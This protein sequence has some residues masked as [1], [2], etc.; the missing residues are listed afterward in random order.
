MQLPEPENSKSIMDAL[1]DQALQLFTVIP[2]LLK[3]LVIFIIGI[4]LAKLVRRLIHRLLSAVGVDK[5][6]DRLMSIDM[7]EKSKINL[8][9]STIIATTT[10]YF[11]LIIFSMA[12]VEA[13]GL[14]IIS[15]LLKDLIEYIPNGVT[16]FLVLVIGIFIADAVKKLILT[17]CRSLGIRSGN[18]IANIVFYFIMLNIVLIALRQAKLQTEFM[19]DNM[20]IIL[21]GIAGAFAIGYGLASKDVITSILAGF[22][23]RDKFHVG[24]EITIDGRRGEVITINNNNIIIRSDESEHVIPYSKVTS[25][26]VEIH[27]RR[28]KGPALPPHEG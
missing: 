22:Y 25:E 28:D 12:A 2:A 14:R 6:A 3:G 5:L 17:T 27:I 10:Y 16:A 7:F 21:A 20:S 19:E 24:D 11:I 8:V 1:Y 4:I 13:M 26:G 23:S 9:P 15:D 18:L